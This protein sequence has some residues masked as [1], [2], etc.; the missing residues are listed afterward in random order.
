MEEIK[1]EITSLIAL[2]AAVDLSSF[3]KNV[4]K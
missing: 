4:S 1:K 3:G 2:P